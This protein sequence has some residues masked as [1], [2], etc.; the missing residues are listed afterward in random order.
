MD[1]QLIY[2][3]LHVINGPGLREV[4]ILRLDALSVDVLE[5]LVELL[6][7]IDVILI[8]VSSDQLLDEWRREEDAF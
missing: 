1:S 6:K 5:D 3:L 8:N 2:F 4:D 7:E